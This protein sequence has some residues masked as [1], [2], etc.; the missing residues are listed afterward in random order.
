M[1]TPNYAELTVHT[2]AQKYLDDLEAMLAKNW[3]IE[4]VAE[5]GESVN[6]W[7]P[8]AKFCRWLKSHDDFTQPRAVLMFTV[9]LLDLAD[10]NLRGVIRGCPDSFYAILIWLFWEAKE[11]SLEM[12]LEFVNA[13]EVSPGQH[14][15]YIRVDCMGRL[16]ELETVTTPTGRVALVTKPRGDVVYLYPP[17][18]DD[19]LCDLGSLFATELTWS[20]IYNDT[21]LDGWLEKRRPILRERRLAVMMGTHPR[22]GVN[23]WKCCVTT[24]SNDVYILQLG[25]DALHLIASFIE[26]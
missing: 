13:Q 25:A 8:K 15:L 17:H 11:R 19:N 23:A 7:P 16:M 9:N 10:A 4:R 5:P 14:R 2:K 6:V 12:H 24:A 20:R 18:A 26:L 21:V 22:L 1:Q 3:R